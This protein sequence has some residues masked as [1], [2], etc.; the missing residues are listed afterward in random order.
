MSKQYI[1]CKQFSKNLDGDHIPSEKY[2]S[3]TDGSLPADR[4]R[5]RTDEYGFIV[6]GNEIHDSS[7]CIFVLGDSLVESI[8]CHE[9]D[10]FCSGLERNLKKMGFPAAVKNAGYSGATLLHLYNILV[11]KIY[12]VSA[13]GVVV[14]LPMSDVDYLGENGGYWNRSLRGATVLP[15]DEAPRPNDNVIP[16]FDQINRLARLIEFCCDQFCLKLIFVL[17]PFR[18]TVFEGARS[19]F[20]LRVEMRRAY[21]QNFRELAVG[22]NCRVID[23][24]RCSNIRC[25]HFYDELHLN[26][27]GQR[28]VSGFL[29]NELIGCDFLE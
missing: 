3:G 6:T 27:D 22:L 7:N 18:K 13:G 1:R 9:R 2:L 14:F 24:E 12:P 26:S 25:E 16:F 17:S 19:G 29:A 28:I 23:F 4:Y 20:D 8:Y 5:L 10:R 21:N 11:N 15:I